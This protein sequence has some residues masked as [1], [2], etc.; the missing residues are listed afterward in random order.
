MQIGPKIDGKFMPILW[1][2]LIACYLRVFLLSVCSFVGVLFV[3]RFKDIARFAA[4]SFDGVKTSLFILYQFPHILPIAIPISALIASFLLFQR[5]SRSHE[6]TALRASG[7]SFFSLLAP[8]LLASLFLSLMNFAICADLAPYCRRETKTLLYR[9]SGA[10]PL[11]LLQRQQLLKIKNTYLDL[12]MQEEGRCA[13]DFLCIAYSENNE[14]LNLI[15]IKKLSLKK[16]QLFGQNLSLL[17]HVPSKEPEGFDITLLEN[18]KAMSMPAPLL[19]QA[20]KKKRPAMET[21]A[22]SL[23]QLFFQRQEGAKKERLVLI[24]VLRRYTLS[25]AVFSFTFLGCAFGI[26][27]GREAKKTP[28]FAASGWTLLVL[29]SYFLGKGLKTFPVAAMAAFLLPHP[30]L[31]LASLYRLS[32]LNRGKS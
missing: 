2:Y 10:N 26:Q 19:S 8:V 25:F 12:Q 32:S 11:V 4:L 23:K 3:L 28:L 15:A 9:K 13:Q 5:L 22:L 17:S 14:R 29:V 20:L 24:E 30:L 1:R 18:Q 7:M 31:W 16:N 6:L 27:S 21:G